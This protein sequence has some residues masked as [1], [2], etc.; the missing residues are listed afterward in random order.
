MSVPRLRLGTRASPLARWQAEWVAGQLSQRGV[1][2]EL[3]PISTQ[4]DV[5]TGPLGQIGGQGLFTKEIQRALL[6]R[7]IDV[8]VHSLK[9][10]P[11]AEVDGLTIAAVPRRE[12]TADVLVSKVAD[13]LEKLP[14]GSRVGTGSLRRKAQLL[15]VRPDLAVLEIR[16]NVDTRLRKLD[17]GEYDAIVL[18]EAGL[19]RLG[20]AERATFV[21]P[22]SIMLP[23]VGQGALAIETRSGDAV[24]QSLV[25]PL[26]DAATHAAVLAER[27]MLAA[28]RGGCLA[29]V[30][31]LARVEGPVLTLEGVVLSGDGQRKI[32]AAAAARSEDA[33]RIGQ[34]VAD[35]LL[36]QGASDLIAASREATGPRFE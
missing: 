6:E 33:V 20:L 7:K 14:H 12:S 24:S 17:E 21:L 10:L 29:P 22:R 18:A 15:H 3:V 4:G 13:S 31:G 5:K 23:A 36:V 34:Q 8:A 26:D 32:S 27:S 16:G 30:G 2:V 25:E 11:T 1:E 28:L 19:R 9:D 35:E